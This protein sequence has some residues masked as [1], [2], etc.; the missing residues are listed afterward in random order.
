MS[1]KMPSL[2][3]SDASQSL[4]RSFSATLLKTRAMY[5]SPMKFVQ[6]LVASTTLSVSMRSSATFLAIVPELP[7]SVL[8][9]ERLVRSSDA[10]S[11]SSSS[12]LS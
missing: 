10:F 6:F 3:E 4:C 7:D 1:S 5:H 11:T 9:E 12:S 2:R 8:L